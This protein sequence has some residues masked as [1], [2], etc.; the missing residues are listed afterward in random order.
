M[1]NWMDLILRAPEGDS[2]GG[3]GEIDNV[4]GGP[5]ADAPPADAPPADAP[6]AD[7]P[8]AD[9]PPADA[10]PADAPPA[11]LTDEQKAEA[12]AAEK[13]AKV[14][15]EGENYEF[16]LPEGM[17]LDSTLAE[18][19][20]PV[21]RELGLT[22]GQAN[23]LAALLAETRQAEADA[24]VESYVT[25]QKSYVAAAKADPE[26]G[27]ANW[28]TSVA[29]ANQALQKFGTPELT[30]ALR[31]HGLQNHPE[32]IR[33]CKRIG[34]HTAD[35]TLDTGSH[36]DTTEVPPEARWYGKTTATTKTK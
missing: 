34:L 30:A 3:A 14:P 4:L 31:E 9:A 33:F 22:T 23:Q 36:V 10:P 19:A 18:K 25:T 12:A 35:D 21:L 8:P 27:A 6:P 16:D 29:Q 5:P 15:G 24:I 28:D 32:M 1:K 13:A 11:E 20:Q 2:P 26:I 7:A 17:E